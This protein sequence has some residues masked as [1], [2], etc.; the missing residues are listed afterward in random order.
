MPIA[1]KPGKLRNKPLGKVF[2]TNIL[3]ALALSIPITKMEDEIKWFL[4]KNKG[5]TS[6]YYKIFVDEPK[7]SCLE[8]I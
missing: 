3:L 7:L 5:H 2:P 4:T 6:P 1:T 8:N